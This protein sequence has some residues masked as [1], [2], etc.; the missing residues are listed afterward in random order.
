MIRILT[1]LMLLTVSTTTVTSIS[2]ELAGWI[3]SSVCTLAYGSKD[4]EDK[5]DF[6][7][8]KCSTNCFIADQRIVFDCKNYKRK[9]T[10]TSITSTKIRR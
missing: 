8:T 9:C 2:S 6:L 4:S 3:T 7:G 10:E 1:L 5:I